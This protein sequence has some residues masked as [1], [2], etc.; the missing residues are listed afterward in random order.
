[1]GRAIPLLAWYY[2]IWVII[3]ASVNPCFWCCTCFVFFSNL[4]PA[5]PLVWLLQK[6]GLKRII[7]S[8]NSFLL[9]HP[10]FIFGGSWAV[11]FVFMVLFLTARIRTGEIVVLISIHFTTSRLCSRSF[12]LGDLNGWLLSSIKPVVSLW[13]AGSA[14]VRNQCARSISFPSVVLA[15][16]SIAGFFAGFSSGTIEQTLCFACG[17]IINRRALCWAAVRALWQKTSFDISLG[18]E[19]SASYFVAQPVRLCQTLLC[20]CFADW[21]V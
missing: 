18:A 7:G 4:L 5:Q 12:F 20:L 21:T 14:G 3:S 9:T 16:Q 10:F 1:M 11:H 6:D 17:C 13:L 19:S 2:W 8:G 15:T